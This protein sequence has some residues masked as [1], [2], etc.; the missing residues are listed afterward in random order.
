MGYDAFPASLVTVKSPL[1]LAIASLISTQFPAKAGQQDLQCQS[2]ESQEISLALVV[3]G[4]G[5]ARTQV[6]LLSRSLLTLPNSRVFST[7]C[8]WLSPQLP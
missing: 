7:C 4:L 1:L 5:I 8:S 3:S 2:H 6:E